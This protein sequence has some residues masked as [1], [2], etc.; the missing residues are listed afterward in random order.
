MV[1]W[2][3]YFY[4]VLSL[5][6]LFCFFY[7]LFFKVEPSLLMIDCIATALKCK[8]IKGDELTVRD[9]R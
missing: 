1:L 4:Y 9:S 8:K 3:K 6:L 7:I 2:G 5:Y